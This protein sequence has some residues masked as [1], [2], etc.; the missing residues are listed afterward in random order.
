MLTKAEVVDYHYRGQ[1]MKTTRQGAAWNLHPGEIL[2][3]DFL[4][5]FEMSSYHLAKRLRSSRARLLEI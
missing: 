4:K 2:R 5:P 3:E 1:K